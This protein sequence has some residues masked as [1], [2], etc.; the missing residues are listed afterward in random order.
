MPSTFRRI[1][2]VNRGEAAMRLIHAVRELNREQPAAGTPP[3]RTIALF[4]DPDRQAMF[5]READEAVSLGTATF[6]DD[7]GGQR[8]SR[9]L[10]YQRLEEV[11]V[12]SGAEAAWVGW[13]FVAE[14]AAFAELCHRL[15]I[16]F[17]GPPAASIRS[18]GDKIRSKQLATRLGIRVAPWS[19]GP[20]ESPAAAHALAERV[21]YPIMLKAA[22]GGGGR[23]MRVVGAPSELDEAFAQARGEAYKAFGDPTLFLERLVT[24][25]R[26]VE[27][28]ILAD[29][30]GTTWA[31]GVR[32]CSIQRRHQKVLEEAPAPTLT[33]DEEEAIRGAAVRL[34]HAV[35]YQNA[36]TVEFLVDPTSRALYFMEVNTRL[37]VE[38]PVTEIT[39]GID[40]VKLQLHVAAGGRLDC[41]PPPPRG[42]AIEAR[43]NAEDPDNHF[44]PA[45]GTIELLRLPTGPG[46]RIDTGVAEGDVVTPEFDSMIAKI[47]AHGASR[48]EALAR[49]RRA[50][51]DSV[52][53]VRGGTTN[54]AFLL[55]L[56]DQPEVTAATADNAWL[57]RLAATGSHVARQHADLALLQTAIEVYEAE[58]AIEQARFYE[59]AARGRPTVDVGVGHGAALRYR[60]HP[61]RVAVRRLAPERYRVGVDGCWVDVGVAR[62]AAFERWVMAGGRG[63]R[64][65]SV[66]QG[67]S[68]LVEVEG[69]PHR[70]ARDDGG[71]IRAPS[72]AVV[73]SILVRPGDV[74]AAGDPL[75]MLEAMKMEM[76]VLA[77]FAGRVGQILVTGNVQVGAG[78]P[79]VLLEPSGGHERAAAAE[80][81]AFDSLAGAGAS[82]TP[83]D[84]ALS[85]LQELRCVALG[86][87]VDPR[88]ARR[89]AAEYV[90]LCDD[91]TPH[92]PDLQQAEDELLATFADLSA[93][94]RRQIAADDP[95]GAEAIR[96]EE[97]L[98]T[99]LRSL[100]RR[101]EGL[102]ASFVDKLRRA[103]RHYDVPTL[104]RSPALEEALVRIFRA[105]H[106]ADQQAAAVVHLLQRRMAH[107]ADLRAGAGD[108]VRGLLDQLVAVSH[109]RFPAVNDIAREVRYR[110]FDQPLFEHAREAVYAQMEAHLEH[111]IRLPAAEDREQ[112]TV[113]LVNCPQ[114]LVSTLGVRFAGAGPAAR[115][116]MLEVLTRRYY[117]IRNLEALRGATDEG[118]SW[119][120]AEYDFEGRRV[121]VFATHAEYADLSAAAT[122]LSARIADV[123]REHDVVM[124]FYVWASRP[125]GDAD[126]AADELRATFNRIVFGRPVR[127][128]VAVLGEPARARGMGSVQHFTY[129]PAAEGYR[130]ER[131]YRGLHPMMGKRMHLWRLSNFDIRRLPSVEDVYLF[132]GVAKQNPKDE[133]LFAIAEVRDLTPVR[134]GAGRVVQLPYLEHMLVEAL[135]GIRRFQ[136]QRP[137]NDRLP[138]NRILLY[139]WPPVELAPD[140]LNDLARRLA[141]PTEGLGIEQVVV[142]ARLR[143]PTTGALQDRVLRL[144]NP[145]GGGLMITVEPPPEHPLEP[146]TE[147]DQKV[148]RMR[149][150]GLVYP[151]EIIRMLAPRADATRSAFP[152]GEFTEYDLDDGAFAPVNRPFGQNSANV[153]TGVIRNF[154]PRY[155][156][157]MV[158]VIILGDPSKA[159]GAVA[160]PECRRIIAALDLAASLGAPLEWFPVSAGA[161][162][163]ME[164][165]TENMD[166][167]ALVLRRLIE[168]TQAGGEVN[169]VVNGI[170]VGA[171]PYWN[172]E[173]TMLLHTRGILIMTP[174]GAMV[175]TGKQ[176]LDYSGS[177]S[178]EDNLG[179]GGYERIMGPNGQAQYWARDITDAAQILF[180]HYEHA[181]VAPGERFPRRAETT[182]PATRDVCVF[183]HDTAD[184]AVVGDIFSP[185]KNP[186]RK[187]PFAIRKVMQAVVDRDHAPLERWSALRDA[188]IAVVW[189]AHLGGR[190]VCLLGIESHPLPRLG[191]LPAD[192]PDH[193]TAGTLFPRSSKKVARAINAASSN[194]PLVI[195]ANLSGFDGSPESMRDLQLEYGAEIGRAVVNFKGPMVFCVVSRYHG[196]A[197]VVFSAKLNEQL[198]VAALEGSYASVIGGAPAAAVVFAGEVDA[199]T[200]K[201]D[202]V[203]TLERQ[204]AAAE[205]AEKA[206]LR[207]ELD[208]VYKSVHAEKLGEVADEFDKVH[209]VQ[210]ALAVGSLHRIIPPRELRPYLIEAV[211]RKI[212]TSDK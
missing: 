75:L 55:Q 185:A 21:G 80:R 175:L 171:Q 168:F 187:H 57:D 202:R 48:D 50:L 69:I 35:G 19:D 170:N 27:V 166:W 39:T 32:D 104:D 206:R 210:R 163:S 182:D 208:D 103:L 189:D 127:R 176:A 52:V 143:E 211:E 133:R 98:F 167:I 11:L 207:G 7:T 68:Y 38:H 53:V 1:A 40:L 169:V 124:D 79:L 9:Y 105:H 71:L 142:R 87:D 156:E 83:T 23:G 196:G 58:H 47:I 203:A 44:A 81:V 101:G 191:F 137:T 82:G 181:Y 174:Q 78:T 148:M 188:E 89:L 76:P 172:A 164:S 13:G 119:M 162:I 10:D 65:L 173:A 123:P 24:G 147:Y 64:V 84:R 192:G 108:A 179:I 42:Y 36:G 37:Q 25:A 197:Y 146:L 139:V 72:P 3:L 45:P 95:E 136:A 130:E 131:L 92:D 155:P 161:K 141:P 152:P 199:R 74:V 29:R 113:A 56:L 51:A 20:V 193:W 61:Y 144:S 17:V 86:Y 41:T 150:R 6:V 49:L 30:H 177:V 88:I 26:H 94:F 135:S 102:P 145:H 158:R 205:G 18:L 90:A 121:H 115:Q 67:S 190:P 201:D 126:A 43:L 73:L 28:Q 154:T 15:G 110:Y 16:V 77:P 60:G 183:P 128:I 125:L 8:K 186:G 34:C 66:P 46:V 109:G 31:V 120:T 153:V 151:Y 4:T 129:R 165:G 14:H 140:E 22:A 195:L 178:A 212:V 33:G 112:R 100:D 54:K 96:S 62:R 70:V 59:A 180:R 194:R 99:Y 204:V 116:L 122:R 134:D 149:Q 132:H 200:R 160:E 91:C 138:W 85:L 106:S 198:E 5:V 111:L 184:F 209:S 12:A 107:A 97:Y 118:Q 63:Y 2:I 114:P 117:R 157:G 93:L 159:M